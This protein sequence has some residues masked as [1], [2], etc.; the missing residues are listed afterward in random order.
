MSSV[1]VHDALRLALPVGS[2]VVAGSTGLQRSMSWPAVARAVAPL[3]ADL[4]GGEFALISARVLR[5]SDPPLAL[6]TLI[7]RLSSVPV[8]AVA[9]AGRVDDAARAVAD[10]LAIPL[11]QL[12]DDTDIRDVDRELQRLVSDFDAQTDRRAAQIALELGELALTGA[13][14]PAMV[15]LLASRMGRLVTLYSANGAVFCADTLRDPRVIVPD[16]TP[17]V[18]RSSQHG[19]DSVCEALRAGDRTLGYIVLTGVGLTSADAATLRRTTM[20]LALEFTKTQ[21]VTAVEARFRGNF[22]EQVL[23]GQLTD[24][25]VIQQRAREFGYDLSAGQRA[26]LFVAGGQLRVALQRQFGAWVDR[27]PQNI[28]WI[29]H[30]HGILCFVPEAAVN[31]SA[32]ISQLA[33]V[34]RATIPAVRV[35]Q[36]RVVHRSDDWKQS[37]SDAL[38]LVTLPLGGSEQPLTYDAI[39]VY[40]L[41]LPIAAQVDTKVF[42]RHQLTA[43]LLYDREQNGELMHTLITYFDCSGSLART[44]EALHVHRNT[45]LYRLNRISQI[46]SIDLEDPEAR[47]CLWLA[48]KLHHLYRA[49]TSTGGDA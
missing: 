40:Q 20:A 5:D 48:V 34:V 36:G 35:V 31:P 13:G 38:Q 45:L 15:D 27:L 19:Y 44:S 46:L 8:S 3:F 21:A 26:T 22:V 29:E 14:M 25:M 33:T 41:L 39:G 37:V 24:P 49:E 6:Q 11:I 18:G 42:Y 28:P 23:T 30:Q 4:R 9:V 2:T 7:E 43:L 16:Y 17:T 12:S 32:L 10:T 47:L 1:T